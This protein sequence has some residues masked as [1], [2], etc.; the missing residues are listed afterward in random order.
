MERRPSRRRAGKHS[1][2]FTGHDPPGL[3]IFVP[4][5]DCGLAGR[6]RVDTRADGGSRNWACRSGAQLRIARHTHAITFLARS[7]R[8]RSATNSGAGDHDCVG[9]CRRAVRP[10]RPVVCNCGGN[11]TASFESAVVHIADALR[12]RRIQL[13][14]DRV[15]SDSHATVRW[16][17]GLA[18]CPRHDRK[19]RPCAISELEP[20]QDGAKVALEL[21]AWHR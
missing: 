6:V 2:L 15:E 9:R 8:I 3:G 4:S 16:F 12:F 18:I 5:H 14:D 21:G 7:L 1:C 10:F 19:G 13:V 11:K 17:P 20:S